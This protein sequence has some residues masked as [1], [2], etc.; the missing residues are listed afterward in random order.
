ME[1][2]MKSLV[3]FSILLVMLS[4]CK[5]SSSSPSAAQG[6]SVLGGVWVCPHW[7]NAGDTLEY[8]FNTTA[9][10]AVDT[11]M[12]PQSY[13][14]KVGDIVLSSIATTSISGTFSCTAELRSGANNAVLSMGT[15]RLV[16][17]NNTL[18]ATYSDISG[19]NDLVFT[20]K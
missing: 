15:I 1:K 11:Y 13:G 2:I 5:K 4:A 14:Y 6:I 10:N 18:T 12:N 3:A 16:L 17:S 20:K 19:Y 7:I 8:T 9:N